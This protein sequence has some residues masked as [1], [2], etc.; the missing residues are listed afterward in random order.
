MKYKAT[1]AN[2]RGVYRKIKDCET[3]SNQSEDFSKHDSWHTVGSH[4]DDRGGKYDDPCYC[5]QPKV[6][7]E[8]LE[9]YQDSLTDS[10]AEL[11]GVQE[12]L[13]YLTVKGVKHYVKKRIKYLER[14]ERK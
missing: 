10:I 7:S 1:I 6:L 12:R 3:M 2:I 13:K 4:S 11:Q 8:D 5:D 14:L 9:D